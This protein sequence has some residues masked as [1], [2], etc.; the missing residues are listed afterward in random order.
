MLDR[1]TKT[2]AHCARGF[3]ADLKLI[4]CIVWLY[5]CL[6]S[7]PRVLRRHIMYVV[8]IIKFLGVIVVLVVVVCDL[9]MN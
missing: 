9:I 7:W 3:T 5:L 4:I 6:C 2:E 1:K 8:L